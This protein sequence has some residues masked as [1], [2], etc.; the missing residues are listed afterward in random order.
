M[1]VLVQSS[2]IDI[3]EALRRFIDEQVQRICRK[4]HQIS[5][6]CVFLDV[7]GRKKNDPKSSQ[8]KFLIM[9]P[10]KDIVV[11]RTATNLYDAI[12]DVSRRAARQL[13]KAQ[14]TR[15]QKARR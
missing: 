9:V 5:K 15:L 8:A 11:K 10:G 4:S 1:R 14:K 13:G 3:T 6:I 12:V 2:S 7:I